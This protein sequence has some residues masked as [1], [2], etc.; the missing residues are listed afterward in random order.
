MTKK[1]ELPKEVCCNNCEFA[2]RCL[3][4]SMKL[5]KLVPFPID[6]HTDLYRVGPDVCPFWAEAKA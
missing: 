2:H 1:T 6:H 4:K 3:L 5:S